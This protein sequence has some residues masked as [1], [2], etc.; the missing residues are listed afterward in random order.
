M[1]ADDLAPDLDAPVEWGEVEEPRFPQRLFPLK[2][3]DTFLVADTYGDILGA[4][5]GLFHD[6]TRILSLWRMSLG[7]RPPT[8]LAG[9]ITE[10]NVV[11]TFHGLNKAIPAPGPTEPPPGVLH[12]ERAHFLWEDRLYTRVSVV[13]YSAVPVVLPLAFEFDADFRDMFEVRGARRRR[14]GRFH[15]PEVAEREVRFRYE[16]LDGVERSSVIAF[17]EAPARLTERR[18]EFSLSLK[19]EGKVDLFIE[20]GASIAPPPSRAR[21]RAAA[22]RARFAMRARRRGARL[23]TAGRL[24]NSWIDKSRADLALLTTPMETGPYPYAGIPWFSTAFG[25]DGIITAWQ[26][27]WLDPSLARGVL[28]YL[29]THQAETVSAFRD[30]QPGKIMHETRRG[31]MSAL[32]EVPFGRY[33]GGVDTTP[34]FVALAGAYFERTGDWELIDSLWP[35][36]DRAAAWI[37]RCAENNRW[38]L[39]DYARGAES[40]LSNQGWKDSGDSVF[41]A[42]GQFPP[43]PISLVE[44]Q[45]YAYAAYRAMAGFAAE[46]RDLEAIDHWTFRAERMRQTVEKMF[47]MEEEGF[48]GI[49]VDGQGN[50]CRV[51]ASNPGHLLFTGLPAPE[52]AIRV[53]EALLSPDFSPAGAS[54]RSPPARPATIR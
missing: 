28:T 54:A 22:A 29:A 13:N 18:A 53:A 23:R 44:V 38:G 4:G 52:R 6:D 50:L 41:H 48:Y 3:R 34:L 25:R 16:G 15:L 26:A 1:S 30:S 5:D 49:A 45:G 43:G 35:A 8:L 14:R 2:D 51:R 11:F 32:G 27:L 42:D 21:Y 17:T 12:I 24:F 36:L 20:V 19:G 39:L 31:E 33:Y 7:P 10:D 46:R 47:W 40:G 9:A 37:V